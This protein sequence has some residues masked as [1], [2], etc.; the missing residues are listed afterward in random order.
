MSLV[1]GITTIVG[2]LASVLALWLSVRYKR[3]SSHGSAGEQ[4]AYR[5]LE[6]DA[7]YDFLIAR[8]DGTPRSPG[9]VRYLANRIAEGQRDFPPGLHK[10]LQNRLFNSYRT[11]QF[12]KV[13]TLRSRRRW[14]RRDRMV[15]TSVPT[16]ALRLFNPLDAQRYSREWGAHLYQLVEEGDIKQA[17]IDRRCLVCATVFLALALRVRRAFNQAR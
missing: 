6:E 10:Y 16:W 2:A 11:A 1:I 17:R 5:G 14:R 15:R 12:E 13:V 8:I 4:L 9:D 3:R 7:I